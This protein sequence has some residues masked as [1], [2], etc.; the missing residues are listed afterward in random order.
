[1]TDYDDRLAGLVEDLQ[2]QTAMLESVRTDL[3]NVEA[4]AESGDKL[5]R[6]RVKASGMVVRI[7]LAPGTSTLGR[8]QLGDLITRTAPPPRQ[9]NANVGDDDDDDCLRYSDPF[10][11]R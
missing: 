1:M 5:V 7:Q 3:E 4:E 6:V 10:D 9:S 8:D 2:A 11:R